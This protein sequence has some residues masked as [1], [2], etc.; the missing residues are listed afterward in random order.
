MKLSMRRIARFDARKRGFMRSL[1]PGLDIHV[2]SK[3]ASAEIWNTKD[4]EVVVRFVAGDCKQHFKL[5]SGDESGASAL[6]CKELERAL[7]PELAEWLRDV[8][9]DSLD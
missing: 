1:C 8:W 5:V 3:R 7:H 6:T 4:G 2:R 9:D